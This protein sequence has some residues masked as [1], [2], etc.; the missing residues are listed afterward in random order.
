LHEGAV[1]LNQ[2][3]TSHE[4]TRMAEHRIISSTSTSSTAATTP[5]PLPPQPLRIHASDPS[6]WPE[7]EDP[8]KAVLEDEPK[9]EP[10]SQT[11]VNSLPYRL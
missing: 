6:I 3:T 8:V 2:Q 10:K 1:Y 9:D 7:V 5:F 11:Q 4:Q